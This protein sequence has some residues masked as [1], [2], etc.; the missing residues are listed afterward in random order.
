MASGTV[1]RSI[2]SINEVLV[3]A[4]IHENKSKVCDFLLSLKGEKLNYKF[5]AKEI[6]QP[7]FLAPEVQ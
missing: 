7:P 5:V 6:S 2:N 3:E 4:I 1:K